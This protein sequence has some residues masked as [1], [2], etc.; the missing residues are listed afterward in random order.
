[1]TLLGFKKLKNRYF[2]IS[3]EDA[4]EESRKDESEDSEQ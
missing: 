1:L 2:D 3:L 4:L